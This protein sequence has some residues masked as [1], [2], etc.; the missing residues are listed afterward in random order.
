MSLPTPDTPKER[1]EKAAKIEEQRVAE[2]LEV[3]KQLQRFKWEIRG[4]CAI[5]FLYIISQII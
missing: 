3:A 5:G 1:D 4:Y 2:A